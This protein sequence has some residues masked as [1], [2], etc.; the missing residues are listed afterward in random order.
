MQ[1]KRHPLFRP[2]PFPLLFLGYI[3]GWACGFW[4]TLA[5]ILRLSSGEP[6]REP[7]IIAVAGWAVIV[8]IHW[9]VKWF[10]FRRKTQ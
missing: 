1:G 9:Q 3:T 6:L 5:V 10:P 7:L 8:W 2:V 4:G